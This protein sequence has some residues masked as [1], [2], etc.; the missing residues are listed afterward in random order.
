MKTDIQLKPGQQSEPKYG[1]V[2]Y[3]DAHINIMYI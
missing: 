2:Q 3:P 1:K